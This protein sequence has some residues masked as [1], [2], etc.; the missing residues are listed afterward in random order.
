MHRTSFPRGYHR[1][2]GSVI[3]GAV[4]TFLMICGLLYLINLMP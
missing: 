1:P 4:R 2:W 3:A